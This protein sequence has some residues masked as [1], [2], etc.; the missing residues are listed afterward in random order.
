M[1]DISKNAVKIDN[2]KTQPTQFK[3]II[4]KL[5]TFQIESYTLNFEREK[6]EALADVI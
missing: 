2:N 3:K 6:A 4:Q 1:W 5:R